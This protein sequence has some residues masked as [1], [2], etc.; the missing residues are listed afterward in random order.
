MYDQKTHTIEVVNV[1]LTSPAYS[2]EESI[3]PIGTKVVRMGVIVRNNE[4]DDQVDLGIFENG[5]EKTRPVDTKFLE[6]TSGGNF[7]DSFC[8]ID[9]DAGRKY[10]VRLSRKTLVSDD[11]NAQVIFI[12]QK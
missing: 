8:P 10:E 12:V 3:T 9:L 7:L 6:K 1:K 5:S 2:N 4:G 11:I